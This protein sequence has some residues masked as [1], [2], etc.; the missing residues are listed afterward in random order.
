MNRTVLIADGNGARGARI[1]AACEALQCVRIVG[2]SM[3][4]RTLHEH[5]SMFDGPE[6]SIGLVQNVALGG[7]HQAVL[8]QPAQRGE[9]IGVAHFR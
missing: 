2:K 3:H 9:G 1:A 5:E 6:K 4:L 8:L 7:Q